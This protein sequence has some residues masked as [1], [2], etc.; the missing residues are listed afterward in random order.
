[1]RRIWSTPFDRGLDTAKCGECHR[2]PRKSITLLI[3]ARARY[4]RKKKEGRGEKEAKGTRRK[5]VPTDSSHRLRQQR[6]SPPAKFL[7]AR[8]EQASRGGSTKFA[9]F[10]FYHSRLRKPVLAFAS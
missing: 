7:P 2:A 6:I 8:D 9:E 5:P 1:M 4:K 3:R 10:G